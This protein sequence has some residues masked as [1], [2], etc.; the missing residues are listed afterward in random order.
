[1]DFCFSPSGARIASCSAAGTVRVWDR[2]T[3]TELL[4]L[5]HEDVLVFNYVAWSPDGATIA[6]G[7]EGFIVA[8]TALPIFNGGGKVPASLS[9]L[10]RKES[11]E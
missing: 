5:E 9:E 2:A 6:A 7:A 4:I 3:G 8:W 10:I 11:V 1:M